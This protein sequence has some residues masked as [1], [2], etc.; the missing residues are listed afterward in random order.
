MNLYDGT[1]DSYDYSNNFKNNPVN[2]SDYM[3][4]KFDSE[5][6]KIENNCN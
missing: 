4:T 3:T 1:G 5:G 6:N 2:P